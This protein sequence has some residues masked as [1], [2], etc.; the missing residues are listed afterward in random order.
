MRQRALSA[1]VAAF[2]LCSPM[3]AEAKILEIWGS[4]LAG[5]GWG[6]GNTDKDFYRW[7][8]G[9]AAGVEVGAKVLFISGFIDYLRWF[10]GDAGANML[11]FNLGGDGSIGLT[12]HLS[13]VLRL[14][15]A[16]YYCT[17]PSDATIQIPG[18]TLRAAETNTRGVGVRGGAG[19]RY[20]FLKVFSVGMTPE[21][22]YHYFFGG[23]ETP[24]TSEN[25]S[26]VDINLLAYFRI[27]LGI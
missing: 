20:T 15:G 12:E 13:L 26:G 16:Y 17:L 2:L 18:T 21:I 27:G 22:G 19:L 8:R 7:A 6:Q 25:S 1:L 23:A 14:A 3:L 24:I 5:Y 4:G 9:G 10:G 11:S